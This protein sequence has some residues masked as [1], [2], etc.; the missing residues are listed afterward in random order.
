MR[1]SDCFEYSELSPSG[2]FWKIDNGWTGRYFVNKIGDVVGSISYQKKT[3]KPHCWKVKLNGKYTGVHR[4]IYEMC[5][6]VIPDNMVVDHINRNPLDNRIENL[7]IVD[8]QTNNRNL[9][10]YKNNTSGKTG[11]QFTKDNRFR[12]TWYEDDKKCSKS[13]SISKFGHNEAKKLAFSF[14]DSVLE[15]LKI[16]HNYS[17]THGE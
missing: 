5:N 12:V 8:F 7:R 6:G 9:C 17:T 15:R 13:F 11:V 14:R 10:K 2:L 3:G 4:I 16:T 1:Y